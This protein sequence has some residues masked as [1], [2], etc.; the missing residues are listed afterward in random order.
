MEIMRSPP[1]P[2]IPNDLLD[3][4]INDGT[5]GQVLTTNGAGNFIFNCFGGGGGGL[6]Y[7]DFVTTGTASAG[8]SLLYSNTNGTFTFRRQLNWL[9]YTNSVTTQLGSYALASTASRCK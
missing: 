7:T 1:P 4:N 9:C 3:L 2:P 8:G 6:G 5:A